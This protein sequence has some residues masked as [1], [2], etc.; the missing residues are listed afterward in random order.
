MINEKDKA[1]FENCRLFSGVSREEIAAFLEDAS[2]EETRFEKGGRIVCR[3][4]ALGILASGRLKVGGKNGACRAV[5]NEMTPGAVFGFAT[6]YDEEKSFRCDVWA[7]SAARIL[8]VSEEALEALM[9]RCPRAAVNV[10]AM[11]AQK[12]RFLNERIRSFTAGQCGDKLYAYLKTLGQDGE[13][14]VVLPMGMAPLAKR[15][16]VGRASLYR[17]FEKLE[18]EGILRKLSARRYQLSKKNTE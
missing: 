1:L 13:G 4:N 6:L 16:D 10:I 14:A 12:I 11:Q 5:I 3:K 18:N 8:W 2:L 9:L 17:A 7:K 15:L